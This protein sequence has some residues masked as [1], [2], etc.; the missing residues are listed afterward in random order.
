M[1]KI[2]VF[3]DDWRIAPKGWVQAWN[4]D[5]LVSIFENKE[6]EVNKLSLD[7]DLGS[8]EYG[9]PLLEGLDF[10]K[11]FIERGYFCNRIYFHTAN[12]IAKQNM[13]FD[14][15][16]AKKHGI[17]SEKIGIVKVGFPKS[18][19]NRGDVFKDLF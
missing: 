13:I 14:L 15:E 1:K 17:I 11:I 12:P 2:N 3:L 16:S 7:N 19:E 5:D 6:Y 8:N 4:V 10:V 9:V 18:I